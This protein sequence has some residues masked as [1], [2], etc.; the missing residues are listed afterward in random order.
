MQRPDR[1]VTRQTF[2][3]F[4]LLVGVTPTPLAQSIQQ[5]TIQSL[6]TTIVL[7]NPLGASRVLLG[8][9]SVLVANNNGLELPAGFPVQLRIPNERQLYEVQGPLVDGFR[10]S[11]DAIPFVAWDITT[12]Y[13][14]AAVA[15]TVG[16]VLFQ[17]AFK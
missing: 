15:H 14:V 6:Y 10:C 16:V 7:S 3:P 5:S 13:L 11:A 1:P 12:I 8:D 9:S 2:T 17:E 4:A